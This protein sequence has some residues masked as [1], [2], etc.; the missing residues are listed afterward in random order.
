MCGRCE[1]HGWESRKH[2]LGSQSHKGNKWTTTQCYYADS[3]IVTIHTHTHTQYYIYI[4]K[5]GIPHIIFNLNTLL[6]NLSSFRQPHG[7]EPCWHCHMGSALSEICAPCSFKQEKPQNTEC[8]V[9][10]SMWLM[11]VKPQFCLWHMSKALMMLCACL[12][13]KKT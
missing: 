1:A 11:A 4:Y 3:E 9:L 13:T 10:F 6:L 7:S 12:W 8:V 2:R 5:L